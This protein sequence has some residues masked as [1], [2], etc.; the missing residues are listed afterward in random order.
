MFFI[1]NPYVL[2]ILL[3]SINLLQEERRVSLRKYQV[4]DETMQVNEN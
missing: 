4:H 3:H 1:M 2:I